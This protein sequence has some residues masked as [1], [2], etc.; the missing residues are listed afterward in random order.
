MKGKQYNA[1]GFTIIEVMLVVGIISV[2]VLSITENYSFYKIKAMQTEGRVNLRHISHLTETYKNESGTYPLVDLPKPEWYETTSGGTYY[3]RI[4]NGSQITSATSCHV[5]NNIIGFYVN[6]CTK[7]NYGYIL[8]VGN[9]TNM[10]IYYTAQAGSALCK[11]NSIGKP[12][13][14]DMLR[15]CPKPQ[16]YLHIVDAV[17]TQCEFVVNPDQYLAFAD[18]G[19]PHP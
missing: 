4:S 10:Q 8:S 17:R 2:M 18:C 14:G 11:S 12:W 5:A 6:D 7:A 3:M 1:K 15:Y 19:T 16:R 9:G 13:Q